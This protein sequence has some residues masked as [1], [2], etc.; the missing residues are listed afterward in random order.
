MITSKNIL[1]GSLRTTKTK[2]FHTRCFVNK[3]SDE[4]TCIVTKTRKAQ[5]LQIIELVRK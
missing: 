5:N 2:K 1:C 4:T 3:A